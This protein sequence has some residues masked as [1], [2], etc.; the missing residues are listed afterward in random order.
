MVYGCPLPGAISESTRGGGPWFCREHFGAKSEA[1][2]DITV[3]LRRRERDGT[4]YQ[5][6]RSAWVQ[7][8]RAK[9][10][11]PGQASNSEAQ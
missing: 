4:L 1:W 6:P 3:D 8:A 11:V 9:V 7:A 2:P 5:A 10:H